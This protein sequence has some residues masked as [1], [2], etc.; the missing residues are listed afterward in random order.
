MKGTQVT[1]PDR[2]AGRVSTVI[3]QWAGGCQ[4]LTVRALTYLRSGVTREVSQRKGRLS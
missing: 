1:A 3:E 2:E 4:M